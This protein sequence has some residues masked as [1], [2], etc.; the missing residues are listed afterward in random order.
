MNFDYTPK[1]QDLRRRVDGFMQRHV[2]PVEHS[3]DEFVHDPANRWKQPPFL[4]ELKAKARAEGLWNLFM[5]HEYGQ[6]SPGLTNL[7]LTAL[8]AAGPEEIFVVGSGGIV[9]HRY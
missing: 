5:P 1:V 2:Y 8:T 7:E 4:D 3:Y 6:W 9:L